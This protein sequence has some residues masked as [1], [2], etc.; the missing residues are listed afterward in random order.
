MHTAYRRPS[1]D[2][3]TQLLR[4]TCAGSVD[5]LESQTTG[6]TENCYGLDNARVIEERNRNVNQSI[7]SRVDSERQPRRLRYDGANAGKGW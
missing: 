1:R 6:T 2:R 7:Y 4:R 3:R 5:G